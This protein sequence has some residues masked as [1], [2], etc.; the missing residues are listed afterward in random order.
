MCVVGV[1]CDCPWLLFGGGGLCWVGGVLFSAGIVFVEAVGVVGRRDW[2]ARGAPRLVRRTAQT[3]QNG[4][5]KD[6]LPRLDQ[7]WL[8][9]SCEIIAPYFAASEIIWA[10]R[11]F[12]ELSVEAA[13]SS[14]DA[15]CVTP[16]GRGGILLL[17]RD[18][19]MDAPHDDDAGRIAPLCGAWWALGKHDSLFAFFMLLDDPEESPICGHIGGSLLFPIYMD[20]IRTDY[21]DPEVGLFWAVDDDRPRAENVLMRWLMCSWQLLQE[22][23][24][25]VSRRVEAQY[26]REVDEEGRVAGAKRPVPADQIVTVKSIRPMEHRV[27]PPGAKDS[28]GREYTR[29][30]V[31]R[32]H[33]RN[34]AVGKDRAD[35]RQTW[36]PAYIKGPEGA[37]LAKQAE[38]VWRWRA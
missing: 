1:G 25:T 36:I 11:E 10:D 33:W 28:E 18:L 19:P 3:W 14:S 32:G 26:G 24:V 30:W 35:R 27:T 38:V 15:F 29:R 37:P 17:A 13:N 8:V 4:F 22:P 23:R 7:H 12:T 34:Q 2:S 5:D 31:V 20:R 16:P 9:D 6:A 21:V